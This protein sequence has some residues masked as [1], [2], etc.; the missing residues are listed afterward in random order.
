MA[1]ISKTNISGMKPP[2]RRTKYELD[3]VVVGLQIWQAS[4]NLNEH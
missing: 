1:N 2:V 3:K 4:E